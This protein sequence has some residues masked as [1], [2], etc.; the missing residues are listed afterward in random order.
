MRKYKSVNVLQ[1]VLYKTI[2]I[3][4]YG[5]VAYIEQFSSNTEFIHALACF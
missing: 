4:R 5:M 2:S 1:E 3:S